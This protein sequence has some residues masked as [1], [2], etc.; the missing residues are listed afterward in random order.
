MHEQSDWLRGIPAFNQCSYSTFNIYY[1]MS[2]FFNIAHCELQEVLPICFMLHAE[3][4]KNH[5]D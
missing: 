1:Y 5:K 2:L 3:K 4:V